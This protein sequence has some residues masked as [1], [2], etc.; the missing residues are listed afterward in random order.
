MIS[1]KDG[2]L[3]SST[4]NVICHQVNCQG[5]M[6]AGIAKTIKERYPRVFEQFLIKHRVD[7]SHLGDIDIIMVNDNPKKFV[8][9]MYSQDNY[10]PRTVRHTDYDA[11][12][13]CIKKIKKQISGY[14]KTCVPKLEFKIGFP[15][16]IGCGLAG[17]DWNIVSKIIED[18][19][20]GKQWEVEIWKL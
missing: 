7:G 14:K 15:Y 2:D 19:F 5:A 11:F 3:L 10:L 8:V 1:Y 17:G 9:N 20:S 6:G 4:C 13:T 12:R 16:G 18:E